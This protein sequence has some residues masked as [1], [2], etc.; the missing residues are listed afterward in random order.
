MPNDESIPATGDDTTNNNGESKR[1]NVWLKKEEYQKLRSNLVMEGT[2]V[3][4]WVRKQIEIYLQQVENSKQY[5][6]TQLND[7]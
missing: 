5:E 1:V 3:S 4:K 6:Q 7:R 2:S